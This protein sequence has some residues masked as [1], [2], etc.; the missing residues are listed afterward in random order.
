MST[1]VTELDPTV[2][3]GLNYLFSYWLFY[4]NWIDNLS[5]QVTELYPTVEKGLNCLKYLN[6]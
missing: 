3:E 6:Y 2:E 1:Q 5:T 4:V